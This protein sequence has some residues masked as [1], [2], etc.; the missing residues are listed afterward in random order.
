[1][2]VF[3]ALGIDVHGLRLGVEAQSRQQ[4]GV[5]RGQGASQ[6]CLRVGIGPR[7]EQFREIFANP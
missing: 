7:T 3:G 5:R 1:V 6:S 4:R 2:E